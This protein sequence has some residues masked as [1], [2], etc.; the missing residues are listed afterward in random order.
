M[1]ALAHLKP[2]DSSPD[3]LVFPSDAGTP[4]SPNNVRNH[5]LIAACKRAGISDGRLAYVSIHP[6]HLGKSERRK[7]QALQNQLATLIPKITLGVYVQPIPEAQRQ[8]AAKVQR[9]LLPI[10]SNLTAP[11]N[12]PEGVIQ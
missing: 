6:L 5:V 12:G 3:D 1:Q 2:H 7:H 10:A 4:L 11:G 8:I 9:G